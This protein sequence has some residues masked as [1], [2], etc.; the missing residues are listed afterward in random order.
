[1]TSSKRQIALAIGFIVALAASPI[2]GQE[3]A[4]SLTVYGR[5]VVFPNPVYDSVA[6]VEFPFSLNRNEL[7]FYRVDSS[8]ADLYAYVFAQVNVFDSMDL[9]LDSVSTYFSVRVQSRSEAAAS[10]YRVFN[11]VVRFFKPG[12]YS[13][14]LR[15]IDVAGG[16]HGDVFLGDLIVEPIEKSRP[17]LSGLTMAYSMTYVGDSV[18]GLSARLVKSGY[19]VIPNPLSAFSPDEDSVAYLYGE[20]YNLALAQGASRE[21]QLTVVVRDQTGSVFK[22]FGTLVREKPSASAVIAERFELADWPP[23]RYRVE[24]TVVDLPSGLADTATVPLI[25]LLPQKG[26]IPMTSFSAF[27]IY[28]TL[29]LS[30]KIHL[31]TYL[32]TPPEKATLER[33]TDEGKLNFLDQYWREHDED[34]T[35]PIVE[36]RLELMSRYAYCVHFFSTNE[37]LRDGWA[38]HRG[39]IYMTYGPCDEI[40]DKQTPGKGN[41][42]QIWYYRSI[43]EGKL[44]VFED[45]SGNQDYRLVH[46]NVY[47]E[48]YSKDWADRLEQHFPDFTDDY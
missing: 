32:L 47:G 25:V 24:V 14:R 1:M 45:W 7:S 5:S 13:T 26:F 17:T 37:A 3:A 41:P 36:N 42:Y 44:F 10:G 43:K 4:A 27:D 30:S 16:R 8:L 22:D 2:A 11:R 38:T 19:L 9:L 39:R 18:T 15:V 35:T 33:L 48:V 40:E 28:D 21:F 46:S 34:P 6:L 20:V 23:G 29:S 12:K 31:V